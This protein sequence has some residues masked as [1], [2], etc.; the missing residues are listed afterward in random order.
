MTSSCASL[1]NPCTLSTGKSFIFQSDEYVAHKVVSSVST[2][3][4]VTAL[5]LSQQFGIDRIWVHIGCLSSGLTLHCRSNS[6]I[7]SEFPGLQKNLLEC[8]VCAG[9][10]TA[11]GM[12]SAKGWRSSVTPALL[13]GTFGYAT[14]TFVCMGL[15]TLVLTKMM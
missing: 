5:R 10:T 12:C 1:S 13:V 4:F 8:G 15:G 11:A 2:R 3:L 6:P 7:H 14:A 9:P